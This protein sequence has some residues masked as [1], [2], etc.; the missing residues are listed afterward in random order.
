MFLEVASWCNTVIVVRVARG[1]GSALSELEVPCST[2]RQSLEPASVYAL[3]GAV[4]VTYKEG[5]KSAVER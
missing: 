5:L 1:S 2:S 4:A 3:L